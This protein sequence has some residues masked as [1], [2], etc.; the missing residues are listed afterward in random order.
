MYS[1]GLY[2]DKNGFLRT[3]ENNIVIGEIAID[4]NGKKCL[5][6]KKPHADTFDAV[7]LTECVKTLVDNIEK[8]PEIFKHKKNKING[9]SSKELRENTK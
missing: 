7:P 1:N 6:I 3:K 8:K 2:V 4:L 5:I 9:S